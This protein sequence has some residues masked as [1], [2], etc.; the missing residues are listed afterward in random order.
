LS[1]AP[2]LAEAHEALGWIWLTS[3][4]DFAAAES[5]FRKAEQLA[6]EDAR[7]KSAL[8]YLLAAH[9]QLPAAEEM[10][11]KALALDPLSIPQFLNLVRVLI[12]QNRYG[13]AEAAAHKALELQPA[14]ARLHTYLV[15]IALLR[16]KPDAALQNAQQEAPGF[17]KDYALA[18]AKQAQGDH[19]AADS[20]LQK[21]INEDAVA[22]P[23]QIAAVYG[24]RKDPD[25]MFEWLEQ[26]YTQH[27]SGLTQLLVTPFLLSYKEDP[28]FTA[29]CQ[30]LKIPAPAPA[31]KR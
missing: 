27:D 26:A 14:A 10:T 19:A 5:E 6:P 12:A 22:G 7:P 4:L 30:K 2:N 20:A 8:S 1:L 21:L 23:F 28:R 25:K 16:G 13:E 24:L 31:A 29:F 18:L 15:T 17:W 11:R 9:G 3:D